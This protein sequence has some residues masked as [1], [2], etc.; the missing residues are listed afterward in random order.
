VKYLKHPILKYQEAFPLLSLVSQEISSSSLPYE[1]V[2]L[3]Q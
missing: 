3:G 1:T 2:N